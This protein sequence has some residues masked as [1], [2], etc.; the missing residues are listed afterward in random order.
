MDFPS[1]KRAL[2]LCLSYTRWNRAQR[3]SAIYPRTRTCAGHSGED[4]ALAVLHVL[5][6]MVLPAPQ[7]IHTA[8][9]GHGADTVPV[10]VVPAAQKHAL[11]IVTVDLQ[12]VGHCGD[13]A[14]DEVMAGQRR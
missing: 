9:P 12:T 10:V 3:S 11:V 1:R 2:C 4:P 13:R 14:W 6:A 8:D 7:D 5:A